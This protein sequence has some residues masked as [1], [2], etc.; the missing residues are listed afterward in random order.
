MLSFRREFPRNRILSSVSSTWEKRGEKR[1]LHLF[2]LSKSPSV[3]V[4]QELIFQTPNSVRQL[5]VSFLLK[6]HL[7]L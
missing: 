6:I 3:N 2:D 5:F 7:C 1:N 4:G